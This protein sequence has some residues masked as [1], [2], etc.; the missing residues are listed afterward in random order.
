MI[1]DCISIL[2]L[3][4]FFA[5]STLRIWW[6]TSWH[7]FRWYYLMSVPSA[8][9]HL[10]LF[11]RPGGRVGLSP[12]GRFLWSTT[13]NSCL[14]FNSSIF[15][16][17]NRSLRRLTRF[18]KGRIRNQ[19][20]LIRPL[21]SVCAHPA[22]RIARVNNIIKQTC[23]S[24][25]RKDLTVPRSPVCRQGC[26]NFSRSFFFEFGIKY[27]FLRVLLHGPFNE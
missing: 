21:N 11:L 25:E 9:S 6:K 1:T 12:F 13:N 17:C 2:S 26:I 8:R 7:R 14:G 5:C 16:M 15:L 22:R 20:D 4:P 18:Q 27:A 3:V 24:N 23:I 19:S 10:C